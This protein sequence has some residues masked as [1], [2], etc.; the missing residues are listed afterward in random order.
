MDGSSAGWSRDRGTQGWSGHLEAFAERA[1]ILAVK[2]INP[3]LVL[4]KRHYLV[5]QTQEQVEH[6]TWPVL[7][8]TIWRKG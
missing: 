4:R 3:T 5:V 2:S 7:F 6:K 8:L 1:Q